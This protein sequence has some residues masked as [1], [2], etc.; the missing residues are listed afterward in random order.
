ML[1]F[2]YSSLSF[3]TKKYDKVIKFSLIDFQ[4]VNKE[5]VNKKLCKTNLESAIFILK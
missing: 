5:I 3:D 4:S 1:R 2:I